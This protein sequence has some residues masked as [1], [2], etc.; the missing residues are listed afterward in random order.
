MKRSETFLVYGVTGILVVILG[1]AVVF[2]N[3]PVAL[4]NS[5]QE[6]QAAGDLEQ[7]LDPALFAPEGE[8]AESEGGVPGGVDDQAAAVDDPFGLESGQPGPLKAD[9]Y[10][11]APDGSPL[12]MALSMKAPPTVDS[13]F[14]SSVVK[15]VGRDARYRV[16]EVATGD[17][18]STLVERW[19][20]SAK[21]YMDDAVALNEQLDIN[22]LSV[23][24]EIWLPYV[25]DG[26]LIAA[27]QERQ[28]RGVSASDF[29]AQFQTAGQVAGEAR[30]G[31]PSQGI[32]RA[33]AGS[34]S[35]YVVKPGESLWVIAVRKVS[36][37]QAKS[38]IEEIL[39]LNPKIT[40][41]SRV[42]SGMTIL[43]PASGS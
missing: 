13:L 32:R 20:G 2:G 31:A 39:S 17:S 10:V 40:D 1:I 11:L 36:P 12:Q 14:G 35:E 7:L 9:D 22:R 5:S 38:Y 28:A 19:C 24:N 6:T 23:G 4:A 29:D 33:S 21:L 25:E 18:F 30:S 8:G 37:R 27:Y 34:G 41:P 42:R 43:L 26:E 15:Q 3:D 16:V